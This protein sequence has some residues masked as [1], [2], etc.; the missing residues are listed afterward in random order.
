MRTHSN[1]QKKRTKTKVVGI[2]QIKKKWVINKFLCKIKAKKKKI[3]KSF[4]IKFMY[5]DF[6]NYCVCFWFYDFYN[7]I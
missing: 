2:E 6:R 1:L 5:F 7:F 3:A 4:Y